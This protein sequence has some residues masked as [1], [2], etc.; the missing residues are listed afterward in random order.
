MDSLFV[1]VLLDMLVSERV[2]VGGGKRGQFR[3]RIDFCDI[4]KCKNSHLPKY[5]LGKR[6]R[7]I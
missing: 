5:L 6:E 4:L 1:K 7:I 3:I 2:V